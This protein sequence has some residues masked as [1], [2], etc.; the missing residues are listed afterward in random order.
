MRLVGVLMMIA[1]W[2]IAIAASVLLTASASGLAFALAAIAIQGV[3]FTLVA[4]SNLT[5]RGEK[6]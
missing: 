2:L 4:R 5:A 3:G 6:N 1:G